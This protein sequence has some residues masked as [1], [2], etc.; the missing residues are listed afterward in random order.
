MAL[1]IVHRIDHP[2]VFIHE[3]D[4]AWDRERTK[5]ELAV[6]DG[7]RPVEHGR[8]VPWKKRSDHPWWRYVAGFTRG[9]LKAVDEYLLHRDGPEGPVKFHF[10]RI[11]N[12]PRWSVVRG[13]EE[14][15]QLYDSQMTALRLSLSSIDGVELEGGKKGEPLTDADLQK[16]RETFGE[17][18]LD[19]LGV[20]AVKFSRE[21]TDAEKKS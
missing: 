8:P 20:V 13:L 4:S 11:G 18:V 9:D 12:M 5:Y 17:D 10:E 15:G 21:L 1:P 16:I 14:K 7:K 3:D 6:I 19:A 2:I